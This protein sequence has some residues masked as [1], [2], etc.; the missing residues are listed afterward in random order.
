MTVTNTLA[1]YGTELI[2]AVKRFTLQ[3][4][5]SCPFKARSLYFNYNLIHQNEASLQRAAASRSQSYKAFLSV[6]YAK[7]GVILV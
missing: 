4:I 7:I 1:Y 5:R 6:I 3:A 2:T